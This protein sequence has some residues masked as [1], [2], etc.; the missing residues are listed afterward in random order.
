MVG[1]VNNIVTRVIPK[2]AHNIRLARNKC[3]NAKKRVNRKQVKTSKRKTKTRGRKK[4][5]SPHPLVSRRKSLVT[6][7]PSIGK[8]R[9][10]NLQ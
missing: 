9:R 6:S 1:V 10:L 7:Q 2:F 8:S 3:K 4:K 5:E